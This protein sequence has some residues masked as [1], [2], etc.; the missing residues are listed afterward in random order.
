[1]SGAAPGGVCGKFKK[2]ISNV[3]TSFALYS[4]RL[5][6]I[7]FAL[8]ISKPGESM[9]NR[10]TSPM[11]IAWMLSQSCFESCAIGNV[12]RRHNGMNVAHRSN[13]SSNNSLFVGMLPLP[14]LATGNGISSK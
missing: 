1:M 4:Q 2:C 10:T 12:R 6:N 8:F 3:E 9:S 13:F 14:A 11:P 7:Q 5:C